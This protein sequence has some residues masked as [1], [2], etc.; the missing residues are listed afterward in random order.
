MLKT[1]TFWLRHRLA[2]TNKHSDTMT[3]KKRRQKAAELYICFL[4]GYFQNFCLSSTPF[5]AFAVH[6]LSCVFTSDQFDSYT[7][8]VFL[9]RH[10][11]LTGS[12]D[13]GLC[14]HLLCSEGCDG[15]V[16][17]LLLCVQECEETEETGTLLP[18]VPSL[19]R[20][21]KFAV[22]FSFLRSLI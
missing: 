7:L 16:Y 13:G 22:L 17:V 18:P 2:L 20:M 8:H 12:G 10:P 3:D 19:T 6:F 1:C 9:S 4:M 14:H 15:G 5:W 21:D 11:S